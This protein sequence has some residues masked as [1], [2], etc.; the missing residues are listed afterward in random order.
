[1]KVYIM[2]A[3]GVISAGLLVL[4]LIPGNQGESILREVIDYLRK[5]VS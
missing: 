5:L 2:A 1:M 4:E 3:I